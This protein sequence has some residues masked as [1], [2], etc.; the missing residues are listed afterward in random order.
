MQKKSKIIIGSSHSDER[1]VVIFNNNFNAEE[2]K[3]IYFI[4][5]KDTE[6]IRGWQGHKIEQRWFSAMQGSFRIVVIAIDNWENPSIKLLQEEFIL[7][8]SNFDVLHVPQGHITRIQALE[9]NARL[10]TMSDYSLGSIKDEYRFTIDYF[11]NR[12]KK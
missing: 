2:V 10:M 12:N 7:E 3:R 9:E 5:N 8:S 1:G 11:T 6:F 4:E